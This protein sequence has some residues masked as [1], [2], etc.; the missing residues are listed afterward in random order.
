MSWCACACFKLFINSPRTCSPGLAS[1]P[2]FQC[3]LIQLS[4]W[5]FK[6]LRRECI[7]Q[8]W[9]LRIKSSI[10]I[11]TRRLTWRNYAIFLGKRFLSHWE[12]SH[13]RVVEHWVL[14]SLCCLH[15]LCVLFSRCELCMHSVIATTELRSKNIIH[16]V[17][18]SQH[19]AMRLEWRR[20]NKT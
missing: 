8:N 3:F 13:C 6:S 10:I 16:S 4:A 19:T 12:F 7:I 14:A 15:H 2:F 9:M 5:Q 17:C 20:R 1:F 18:T 11:I